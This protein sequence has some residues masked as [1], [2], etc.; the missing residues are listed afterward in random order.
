MKAVKLLRT[1]GAELEATVPPERR[2]GGAAATA[3]AGVRALWEAQQKIGHKYSRD[4][5]TQGGEM[6]PVSCKIAALAIC[7]CLADKQQLLAP[8]CRLPVCSRWYLPAYPT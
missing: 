1:P 6:L 2:C 7:L 3:S 5:C 4:S 8:K